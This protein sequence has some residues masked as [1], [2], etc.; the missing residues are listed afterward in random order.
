MS[1]RF[2]AIET[3]QGYAGIV[4]TSRGV[5]RI[6]L[7]E[8]TA[9]A[10]RKAIKREFPAA[11]EDA[12]LM[13]DFA[14][15]LTRFFAGENVAFKVKLDSSGG[16]DFQRD[17]WRACRNIPYGET[18]SYG[19]LAE[20]VGR[21]GGARAVGMVMKHN[22]FPP[23]VPCHRVLKSDGGLGGFSSPGG[24]KTKQSMLEMEAAART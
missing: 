10:L 9:A 17:V 1:E 20:S 11:T 22:P 8:R 21:P 3:G 7:R 24:V 23:V 5:R 14:G 18:S 13:P 6:F 12:R 4:A 16:T 2:R 19:K 15:Q